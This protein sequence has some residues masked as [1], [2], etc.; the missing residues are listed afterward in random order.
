MRTHASVIDINENA[1]R[2]NIRRVH[3]IAPQTKILAMLKANAYGHGIVTVAKALPEVDAFGVACLAE[4]LRLREANV[5]NRIVL[6]RGVLTKEE[7]AIAQQYRIELVI[8]LIEQI[9]LLEQQLLTTPLTVWLKINTGMNRLGVDVKDVPAAYQRLTRLPISKPLHVL[10]HFACADE[11]ANPMTETQMNRFTELT[12][13]L[14]AEKSLANSAGILAWPNSHADWVR[15]GLMLYGVSP[16]E[17]RCGLDH[18]LQP[19]MTWQSTLIAVRMQQRGD[20]IGYGSTWC[21]PYEGLV[22]IVGVGYAD[23]YPRH[24]K[25]GAAVLINNE[26]VNLI[27]RVSMDMLAVDLRSQPY[28]KPGNVVTLWGEGLPIEHIAANTAT[29]AYELLCNTRM[30]S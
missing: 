23:G 14:S 15:P 9:E 7:L 16:F 17:N 5:S 20:V 24:V 28:V 2:H 10:T 30:R 19:V 29:N 13:E 26:R 18:G 12:R 27:G 11:M 22:G 25:S 6:M 1:L 21:C 4:A 3:E 8:H